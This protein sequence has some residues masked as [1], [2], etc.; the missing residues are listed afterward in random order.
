MSHAGECVAV[1]PVILGDRSAPAGAPALRVLRDVPLLGWALRALLSCTSISTVAI[2]CP[3][4]LHEA[5]SELVDTAR[6]GHAAGALVWLSDGPGPG[7]GHRLRDALD[8]LRADTV[9]VHDPLHALA[10]T[11]FVTRVVHALDQ[12]GPDVFA[13]VP[14]RPVTDTLKVLAPDDVIAG[15]A[16]REHFRMV[17]TPQAYRAGPLLAALDMATD[18][19]LRLPEADLLPR[20]VQRIGGRLLSVQA[21]SEVFRIVDEEDLVLAEAMLHVAAGTQPAPA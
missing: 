20:L 18:E 17:Y 8:G 1:M 5:V 15:T 21:P 6:P 11:D 10:A 7:P 9:V 13:A 3:A 14:V 2:A 4:T 16:D 12:A 19:E